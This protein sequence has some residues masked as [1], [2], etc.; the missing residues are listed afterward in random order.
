MFYCSP[1]QSWTAI[2]LLTLDLHSSYLSE[3]LTCLAFFFLSKQYFTCEICFSI[4]IHYLTSKNVFW[5]GQHGW[6]HQDFRKGH[7]RCCS[8]AWGKNLEMFWQLL[9]PPMGA[10]PPALWSQVG[11]DPAR[12]TRCAKFPPCMDWPAPALHM[13]G[14]HLG[15]FHIVPVHIYDIFLSYSYKGIEVV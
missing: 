4:F 7:R 15:K 11:I 10:A 9:P 14:W 1:K 5:H 6:C 12:D 3:S 13:L 8:V 2:R